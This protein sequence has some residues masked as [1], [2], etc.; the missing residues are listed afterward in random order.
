MWPSS[1]VGGGSRLIR[2]ACRW[3][4]RARGQTHDYVPDFIVKLKTEPASYLI[5]EPK[6]FDALADVKL[7]AAERW[8][9]AVNADGQHGT[10]RY[11]Q[12]R[13]IRDVRAVVDEAA[14]SG[15]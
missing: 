10:W 9:S 7:A 11:A 4:W 13:A 3:H 8:V 12:E 5:L 1:G 2:A 14:Q 6:G 15:R